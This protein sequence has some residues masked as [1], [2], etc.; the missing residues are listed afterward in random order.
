MTTDFEDLG[1]L[2]EVAESSSR[3]D[4]G[5]RKPEE[6]GLGKEE[7]FGFSAE[8]DELFFGDDKLGFAFAHLR[9]L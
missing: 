8:S 7:F 9:G 5:T 6:T 3:N 1:E 4:N 2:V